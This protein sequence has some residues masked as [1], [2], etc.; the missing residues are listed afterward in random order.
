MGAQNSI[1]NKVNNKKEIQVNNKKEIQ[2]N[3]KKEIQVNTNLDKYNTN[4]DKYNTNLDKYNTNLV[5]TKISLD[6]T[7]ISLDE[8]K[9]S[10]DENKSAIKTVIS[11]L[12]NVN[13]Q[14]KKDKSAFAEKKGY[15]HMDKRRI[16]SDYVY[17][18]SLPVNEICARNVLNS[19]KGIYETYRVSCENGNILESKPI[20]DFPNLNCSNNSKM[21]MKDN[22]IKSLYTHNAPYIKKGNSDINTDISVYHVIN[23]NGDYGAGVTALDKANKL[24]ND[25][26][27][28]YDNYVLQGGIYAFNLGTTAKPTNYK[29]NRMAKLPQ[30]TVQ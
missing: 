20:T 18:G 8:T 16:V 14:N 23:C 1:G 4:L 7:K 12:D 2:V 28:S 17:D 19:E 29:Y 3:N 6:E 9:I 30:I 15:K 22:N 27:L 13:S 10:L 11:V 26:K 25:N 5:S 21:Y 24:L